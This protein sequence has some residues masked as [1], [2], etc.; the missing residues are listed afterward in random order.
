MKK[1]ALIIMAILCPII[2][3]GCRKNSGPEDIA[4]EWKLASLNGVPA[5]ELAA[6]L[7]GGLD[8]YVFFGEDMTFETFQRIGN[9]KKYYRYS[10]TYNIINTNIATGMYDDGDS[11]GAEYEV[12]LENE[13]K[14]LVMSGGGDECIYIKETIPDEARESAFETKAASGT[15]AP[16]HFL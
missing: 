7:Y 13:G 10:G 16:G 2:L 1:K 8:V 4:G 14:T 3:S 9:S 15:S 6:D 11:W 12:S 5:E